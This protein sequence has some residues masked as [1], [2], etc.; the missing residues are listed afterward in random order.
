MPPLSQALL[1]VALLSTAA[2]VSTAP[3]T[4]GKV[5]PGKASSLKSQVK[6]LSD[7]KLRR[8]KRQV[9]F[10]DYI[11]NND[12][13]ESE[14]DAIRRQLSQLSDSELAALA[15]MV[16]DEV[17]R[18]VEPEYVS[19]PQ[20]EV[21]EIPDEYLRDSSAAALEPY[22]RDRRSLSA[23]DWASAANGRERDN[24]PEYIIVP[25]EA[26]LEALQEEQDEQELR[27]RIAEIAHILNERATRRRLY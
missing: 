7:K 8:G 27:E 13:P 3:A 11:G 9:V 21:I 18:Y 5:A 24:E 6:P 15:D 26:V 2:L 16:R 22:P 1:A 19:V 20:Y 14:G 10:D 23:A 12:A 25:E 4:G 17:G